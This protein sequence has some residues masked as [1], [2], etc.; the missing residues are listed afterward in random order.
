MFLFAYLLF[1]NVAMTAGML[2]ALISQS[3]RDHDRMFTT[4]VDPLLHLVPASFFSPG[5]RRN[6]HFGVDKP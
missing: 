3:R 1:S 5:E 4:R 6:L 2:F